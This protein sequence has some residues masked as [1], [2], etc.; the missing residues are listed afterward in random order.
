MVRTSR[1]LAEME[2]KALAGPIENKAAT[3][4]A[5]RPKPARKAPKKAAKKAKKR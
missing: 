4:R 3:A 1:V 2:A 5:P